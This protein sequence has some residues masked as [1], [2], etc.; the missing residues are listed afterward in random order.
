[1]SVH[2]YTGRLRLSR[3][4]ASHA[5]R[6]REEG[7]VK[8]SITKARYSLGVFP[9]LSVLPLRRPKGAVEVWGS[10]EEGEPFHVS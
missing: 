7:D 10:A 6:L 8:K 1:M 4:A 2:L 9:G 5:Q 3:A